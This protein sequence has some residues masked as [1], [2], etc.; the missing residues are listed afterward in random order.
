MFCSLLTAYCSVCKSCS[1]HQFPLPVFLDM[2]SAIELKAYTHVV[3][4]QVSDNGDMQWCVLYS[5]GS[6][7]QQCSVVVRNTQSGDPMYSRSRVRAERSVLTRPVSWC[8][9]P[10]ASRRLLRKACA[11]YLSKRTRKE[12]KTKTELKKN[13]PS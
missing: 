7:A 13:C 12:K 6:M 11:S 3:F 8:R 4:L 10:A 5:S 2:F 9:R 1:E